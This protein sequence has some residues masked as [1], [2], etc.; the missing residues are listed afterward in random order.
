MTPAAAVGGGI[1]LRQRVRHH[2]H[3]SASGINR[4]ACFQ[5]ADD[6]EKTRC[7]ESR[8]TWEGTQCPDGGVAQQLC[9]VRQD[10]HHSERCAIEAEVAPDHRRIG[11]EARSPKGFA[12][13]DDVRALGFVGG[14]KRPACQ[15]ANTKNIEDAGG[16]HPLARHVFGVAVGAGHD[17]TADLGHVAGHRGERLVTF[18]PIRQIERRHSA[19]R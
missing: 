17:H 14:K 7:A 8:I 19:A 5:P 9:F 12:Q 2:R 11:I 16:G 13:E 3:V 15:G 4:H 1:L 18:G 10:A 6:L